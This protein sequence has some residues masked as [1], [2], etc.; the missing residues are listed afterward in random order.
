MVQKV[1]PTRAVVRTPV[2]S[3]CSFLNGESSPS[4]LASCFTFHGHSVVIAVSAPAEPRQAREEGGNA[5]ERELCNGR[6]RARWGGAALVRGAHAG[7]ARSAP[8]RSAA[9]PNMT[10]H[11]TKRPMSACL[12]SGAEGPSDSAAPLARVTVGRRST[13]AATPSTSGRQHASKR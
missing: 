10:D 11:I 1:T 8:A 3:S 13:I 4:S 5:D 12:V 9:V 6:R 2:M 7:Y